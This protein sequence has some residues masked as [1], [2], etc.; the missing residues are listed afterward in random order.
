MGDVLPLPWLIWGMP[1]ALQSCEGDAAAPAT[2]HWAM[3]RASDSALA[4]DPRCCACEL[5]D[6]LHMYANPLT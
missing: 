4:V 6:A 3:C 2:A 5:S 1:G